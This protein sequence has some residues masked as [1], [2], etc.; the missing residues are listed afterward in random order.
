MLIRGQRDLAG[1]G[2]ALLAVEQK[3]QR[4]KVGT[5]EV[6][7]VIQARDNAVVP[8]VVAAERQR[9]GWTGA[10]VSRRERVSDIQVSVLSSCE[11]GVQL[12]P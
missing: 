10:G 2:T 5:W 11:D 8:K 6:T 12:P 7:T 1:I 4:D 9:S 3:R